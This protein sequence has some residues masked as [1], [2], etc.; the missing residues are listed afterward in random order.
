MIPDIGSESFYWIYKLSIA[1]IMIYTLK[2]SR[3]VSIYEVFELL[4]FLNEIV[5]AMEAW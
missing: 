2:S 5:D 1:S 3:N 4:L